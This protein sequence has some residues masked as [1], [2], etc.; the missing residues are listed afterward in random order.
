MLIYVLTHDF[1][2]N[3]STKSAS[4]LLKIYERKEQMEIASM[5]A[6]EVA[7]EGSAKNFV[8]SPLVQRLLGK[9]VIVDNAGCHSI[10][11]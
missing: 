3:Q 2:P 6:L 5:N 8:S 1:V 11:S 9:K 10:K 4:N 7:I